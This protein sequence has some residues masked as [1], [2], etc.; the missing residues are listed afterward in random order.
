MGLTIAHG[1]VDAQHGSIEVRNVDDGCR[2]EVRLPLVSA[3]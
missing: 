1:L 2:F 3:S